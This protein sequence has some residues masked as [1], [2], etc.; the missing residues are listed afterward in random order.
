MESALDET[1]PAPGSPSIVSF[2]K[3][4]AERANP[5]SAGRWDLA[6]TPPER[7][8]E[9]LQKLEAGQL[10]EVECVKILRTSARRRGFGR[11]ST[12]AAGCRAEPRAGRGRPNAGSECVGVEWPYFRSG[13]FRNSIC[14]SDN[15]VS[16]AESTAP[17]QI[18]TIGD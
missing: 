8:K 1:W 18:P 6:D 9:L 7:L 5:R 16:S 17:S 11:S 13:S 15:P 2:G 10:P 12:G 14:V 4:C 3:G